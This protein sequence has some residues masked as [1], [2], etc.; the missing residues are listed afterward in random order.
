MHHP[1]LAGVYYHAIALVIAGGLLTSTLVTL[2]FLPATYSLLEDV[3]LAT[4][5]GWR[6]FVAR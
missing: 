3:A 6:R 4:A 2:V 1:T 5:A